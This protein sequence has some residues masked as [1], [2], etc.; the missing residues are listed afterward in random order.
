MANTFNDIAIKAP[1]VRYKPILVKDMC[2]L[3]NIGASKLNKFL[4]SNWSRG[5]IISVKRLLDILVREYVFSF[6]NEHEY[7]IK[8]LFE[9][10]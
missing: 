9:K 10:V 2:K 4:I 5:L 8:I 7:K 3:P 1:I 6:K